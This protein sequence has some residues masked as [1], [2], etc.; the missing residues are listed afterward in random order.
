MKK[1]CDQ[2]DEDDTDNLHP[3]PREIDTAR[4]KVTLEDSP[5][6]TLN[7]SKDRGKIPKNISSQ[8]PVHLLALA[9]LE[10]FISQ[11]GILLIM[12]VLCVGSGPADI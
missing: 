7:S 6:D 11:V 10:T 8:C 2:N 1:A 4:H 12:V 3:R 9:R 5:T